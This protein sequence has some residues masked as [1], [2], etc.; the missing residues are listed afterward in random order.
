MASKAE[1]V[2]KDLKAGKYAPVYFLQGEEPFFI[3]EISNY[4]EKHAIAEHE[5]GFNQVIMYGKDVNMSTILGNARRFPM[6]ADRQVVIVKEAQNIP[7]LGK[8]EGDNLLIGYLQNPLPSTILVFA[9]KYKSLD[10]RKQLAKEMDKRAV[11]VK[12][13]KIK[14][15]QLPAWVENYVKA[16][17]HQIDGP[18]ASFLADSIGNNL[19][20]IANELGKMFI[21]FTEPTQVTK[22]HI[23]KFIGINKEYNN[24]ELTKAI[25]FRDVVKANKIIHYFS[26][27]PKNHPLIPLIALT[28]NYFMK[29]AQVHYNASSGDAELARI[30]G[31]NPYFLKE[32]RMAAKNY[33]IGKVIDCFSYLREADLRSKGVESSSMEDSEILRE[34]VFKIMH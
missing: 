15:F 11:F 26:Q 1:D 17:G 30:T 16:Q 8:E 33:P 7:N 21:N 18:T 12:S 5:K 23:Q 31:V 13:E 22:D 3:D 27:N 29:I 24:F 14:D 10:G 4:I 19:E 28:Y 25:G 34:L 9:H 6:M 20:V 2:L 32:Y